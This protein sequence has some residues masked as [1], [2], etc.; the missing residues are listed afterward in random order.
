MDN[1][2]QEAEEK[3]GGNSRREDSGVRRLVAAFPS[4]DSSL[5]AAGQVPV[6]QSADK[7]AHSKA[8]W[9]RLRRTASWADFA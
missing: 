6:P 9:S 7:S 1:S 3:F 2:V 4:S 5:V 8:V